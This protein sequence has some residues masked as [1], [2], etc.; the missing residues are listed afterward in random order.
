MRLNLGC[1]RHVLDGYTNVDVARSPKAARAPEILH[2]MRAGPLPLPDGVAD[3]VLAVHLFEHF[4]RW[5]VDA[6]LADWRRVLKPGAVLVLELPNLE[7]ACR[8][9][10]AGERD[11]LGMW[12]LYGDPSHRDP[13]MCHRW[14]WTSTTL[15]ALLEA[16]G[17]TKIKQGPPQWHGCRV[18]RDMRIE[19]RKA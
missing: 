7:A 2:D 5:E 9:V 16:S 3:E 18:D 11:Q 14:A 8:N 13:F 17:F 4:Y 19:A 6:L 12:P 1:G 10:L 15:R